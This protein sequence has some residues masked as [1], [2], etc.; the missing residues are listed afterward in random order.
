MTIH[1]DTLVISIFSSQQ[2]MLKWSNLSLTPDL[3]HAPKIP[4][5]TPELNP[6]ENRRFFAGIFYWGF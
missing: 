4:H 1:R 3:S 2:F 5:M 6:F